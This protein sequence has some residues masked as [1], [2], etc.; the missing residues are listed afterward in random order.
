MSFQL[1]VAI[2][3]LVAIAMWTIRVHRSLRRLERFEEHSD[4]EL[5]SLR[6]RVMDLEDARDT[7]QVQLAEVEQIAQWT[8]RH[9]GD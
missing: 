8:F 6:K 4:K 7:N 9:R 5:S 2:V 3:F 1:S